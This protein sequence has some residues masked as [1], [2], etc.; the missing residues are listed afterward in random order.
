[1]THL[2]QHIQR[3]LVIIPFS[4][5]DWKDELHEMMKLAEM[6]SDRVECLASTGA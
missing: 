3:Q 6:R 5:V 4:I 1:M 2:L